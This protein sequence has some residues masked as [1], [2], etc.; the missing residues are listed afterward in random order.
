MHV[1]ADIKKKS[2]PKDRR[3]KKT[4]KRL[5]DPP[6]DGAKSQARQLMHMLYGVIARDV[7]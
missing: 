2:T 1:R 3:R 7:L 4:L 5:M 6:P